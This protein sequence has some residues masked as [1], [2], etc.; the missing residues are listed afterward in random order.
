MATTSKTNRHNSSNLIMVRLRDKANIP[1]VKANIW[2]HRLMAKRRQATRSSNRPWSR[3]PSRT[4]NFSNSRISGKISKRPATITFS[5]NNNYNS[6]TSNSLCRHILRTTP[7]RRLN[8]KQCNTSTRRLY[9]N[10]PL[11]ICKTRGS[12][13]SS[14]NTGHRILV[15]SLP[16]SNRNRN[17]NLSLHINRRLLTSMPIPICLPNPT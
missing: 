6:T 1:L 14:N 16:T 5:N 13:I 4:S 17:I 9:S 8:T 15:I 2:P 11:G 10:L 12:R 3:L 7:R